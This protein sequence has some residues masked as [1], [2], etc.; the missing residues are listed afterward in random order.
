MTTLHINA[1]KKEKISKGDIVGYLLAHT[2]LTASHIG[3]ITLR[4]HNALVAVPKDYAEKIV[5]L[6]SPQK[7]KGKRIRISILH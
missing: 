7:L 6:C 2:D 5:E 4:D 1:G 3:T